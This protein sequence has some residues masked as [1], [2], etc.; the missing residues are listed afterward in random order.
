MQ[1]Q[2]LKLPTPSPLQNNLQQ[3]ESLQISNA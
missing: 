3:G 2:Q 1:D